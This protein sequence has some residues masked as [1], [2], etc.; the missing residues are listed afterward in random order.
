MPEAEARP[1]YQ[2]ARRDAEKSERRRAILVAAEGLLRAVGFDAFSM[3][4]LARETGLGR[5]TLYTYFASRE[6]VLLALYVV[7]RDRWGRTIAQ[8]LVEG[9]SDSA[10]VEL[11]LTSMTADPVHLELRARLVTFIDQNVSR[12]RY[13]ESKRQMRDGLAI[14]GARIEACLDLAPGG[15]TAVLTSFAALL[16]GA[17][18][19]FSDP[20]Q[21][22]DG[23]PEDV[24]EWRN[25][26]SR[27]VVFRA[28]AP[29]LL[30]G[31]RERAATPRH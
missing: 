7:L 17:G 8:G 22:D 16:I 13:V 3:G 19:L 10:F 21:P 26:F 2:R 28:H 5:S 29:D 20:D 23:L 18:M 6:E 27:E 15:G 1:Q 9:M 24:V 31:I 30:A 14:A 4:Q 12:E 25:Q 11:Y